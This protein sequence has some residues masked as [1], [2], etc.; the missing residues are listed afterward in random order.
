MKHFRKVCI[1]MTAALMFSLG[2]CA[3]QTRTTDA[4]VSSEQ[5]SGDENSYVTEARGMG[6]A[7]KV[8]T[9][10]I[11]GVIQ[12]VEILQH[13]ETHGISDPA[14]EQMPKQ[15]VAGNSVNVDVVSGASVTSDAII[16]AVKAAI[17]K[18][19]LPVEEFM[20]GPA[21]ERVEREH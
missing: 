18:A 21:I 4:P 3:T 2:A 14:I 19:G 20:R 11:D 1:A 10:I 12:S 8:K 9:V 16:N 7:V 15:I 17:E 13:A 6:G 5:A